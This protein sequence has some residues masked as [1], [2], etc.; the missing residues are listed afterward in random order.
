MISELIDARRSG[1]QSV[2]V[3]RLRLSR[4]PPNASLSDRH[5]A[6]G[7][8]NRSCS[9]D[10]TASLSRCGRL[11]AGCYLGIPGPL[12]SGNNNVEDTTVAK[13]KR[14]PRKCG[15]GSRADDSAQEQ[16]RYENTIIPLAKRLG[17]SPSPSQTRPDSSTTL[18]SLQ[19]EHGNYIEPRDFR[20][21]REAKDLGV[22][23]MSS[24][25]K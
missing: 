17:L 9:R 23:I 1:R 10:A 5:R 7:V 12:D 3:F 15:R 18:A 13:T 11:I 2:K 14:H 16:C 22:P 6:G 25:V 4:R 20:C 8:P 24:L 19:R 21:A